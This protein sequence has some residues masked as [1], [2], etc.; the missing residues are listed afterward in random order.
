MGDHAIQTVDHRSLLWEIIDGVPVKDR[1]AGRMGMILAT[2]VSRLPVPRIV[3][4]HRALINLS[5]MALTWDLWTAADIIHGG[6]CSADSFSS[7]RLWL[8]SRGKATFMGA[9]ADPDSLANNSWLRRISRT[10]WTEWN[11]SDFPHMD[12]ILY[13]CPEAY[14]MVVAKLSRRLVDDLDPPADLDLRPREFPEKPHHP[15]DARTVDRQQMYPDLR[16]LFG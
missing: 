10:P 4:L 9:I 15:S 12:E 1:T 3:G 14:E 6:T 2:Q 11:D 8:I 5:D 16:R 7:F 13:S